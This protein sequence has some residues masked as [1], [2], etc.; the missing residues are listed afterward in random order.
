MG[1]FDEER[2]RRFY[3]ELFD[4]HELASNDREIVKVEVSE[5]GDGGFA[6]ADIDTRWRHR[7][8]GKEMRWKGRIC[9]V[10]S[11]VRGDWKLTMHTGALDYRPDASAAV[12]TW[13]EGWSRAWPAR[14]AA[15]VASLH[16]EDAVFY[17]H[18]FR[19]PQP[20]GDYAAWAFAD[21]AEVVFRFGE[22]L[23]SG[24]RAAL[25]WWR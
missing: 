4:T 12:R 9:K 25:D 11:L 2:W 20:P 18:P 1:R 23:V 16:A 7:E 22:P 8:S 15:L 3:Q 21:Q 24:D 10:Y 5:E 14:D 6:V 17:S 13:I 19:E